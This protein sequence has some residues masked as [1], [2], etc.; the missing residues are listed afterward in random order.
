VTTPTPNNLDALLRKVQ[1]LIATADDPATTPEAAETYRAKAEAL[2]HKYRIDETMMSMRGPRQNAGG[3]SP[4]WRTMFVSR[5][6]SPFARTYLFMASNAVGHVGGKAAKTTA[7]GEDGHTWWV[8]EAVGYESD[9]RYAE[10]IYTA[11]S[12]G[13]ASKMEPK[14]NPALSDEENAYVMR[15]AGWT[16][17]Q[18]ARTL[19]GRDDK[20]ARS[21]ARRMFAQIAEAKG[22]DASVLLGQGNSV[23]VYRD[24]YADGFENEMYSRL[25]RM[26]MSTGDDGALVLKSRGENVR[27]AFYERY[28]TLR[29]SA[30][31]QPE[32]ALGVQGG[33]G[34]NC[35]KCNAAKSGYCREHNYL[36]PTV[37]RYR[38]RRTNSAGYSRG[39]V[40]AR[41]VD[42]GGGGRGRVEGN[43]VR[44]IG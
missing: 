9:L 36:R 4:V 5:L 8:L 39:A 24:S 29:P 2:M 20:A 41:S 17:G 19:W 43:D 32:R 11:M 34:G 16:G 3:V 30:T 40:A 14:H 21:K 25:A 31:P 44:A 23:E 33:P 13:F 26:R 35:P 6:S 12:L 22:E 38:E 10:V 37:G 7:R 42:L 27:E 18:I 1:A 28:P 15:S